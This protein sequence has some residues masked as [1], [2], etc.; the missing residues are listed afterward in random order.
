MKLLKDRKGVSPV[1]GIMLMLVVTVILAAAVNAYTSSVSVKQ[2]TPVAQFDAK[3][4]YSSGNI[5]L[6]MISGDA[7]YKNDIAIRIQV[8]HPLTSGYVN[9]SNVTFVPHGSY[10]ASGDTIVIPFT[11]GKWGAEFTGPQ[12]SLSVAV[13]QPFTVT[14]IDKDTGNPIWTGHLVMN[15]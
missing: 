15:P 10:A 8:D 12:I 11:K 13:G 7:I 4:S 3:A 2:P 9:M 1:V 14:I 6:N 5:T